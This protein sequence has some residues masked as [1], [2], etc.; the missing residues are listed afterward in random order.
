VLTAP[1]IV[2]G[3]ILIYLAYR[4]QPTQEAMA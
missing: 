4:N 3:V 2:F 1:M